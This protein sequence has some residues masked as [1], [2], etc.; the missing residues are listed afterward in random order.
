MASKISIDNI[1]IKNHQ[2]NFLDTI[3]LEI[4]FS[5]LAP[6]AHPIEWKIIYFGSANDEDCDQ[7]LE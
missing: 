5:N 7:V 1:N 3:D 6:L 2:A 4:T